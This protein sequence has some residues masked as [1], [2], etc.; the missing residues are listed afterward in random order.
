MR[1]RAVE[2][3]LSKGK[4]EKIEEILGKPANTKHEINDNAMANMVR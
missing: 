4:P 1:K 2:Y 3:W